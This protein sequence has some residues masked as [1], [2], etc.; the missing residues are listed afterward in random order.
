MF[1]VTV[2]S[3]KSVLDSL[4]FCSKKP[5]V[6][7]GGLSSPSSSEHQRTQAN[8]D[9][10]TYS[11]VTQPLTKPPCYLPS[12]AITLPSSFAFC[13]LPRKILFH[14]AL[15]RHLPASPVLGQT[16]QCQYGSQKPGVSDTPLILNSVTNKTLFIL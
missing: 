12:Q 1:A 3:L 14:F 2:Q 8:L 9:L 11:Y 15:H 16:E 5:N 13:F 7:V 4:L 6:I 10:H